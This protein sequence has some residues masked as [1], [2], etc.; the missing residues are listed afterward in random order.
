MKY[1]LN[2]RGNPTSAGAYAG[3]ITY[4]AHGAITNLT[5]G[6]GVVEATTWDAGLRWASITAS[7]GA[8]N[9]TITNT[10]SPNGN[11]KTQQVVFP[12]AN[13]TQTYE[14]ANIQNRLTG[15]SETG[16]GDAT[17]SQTYA[18]DLFG[19]RALTA[20]S[21]PEDLAMPT[22]L[23]Q[24]SQSAPYK[25]QIVAMSDGT[26][27]PAQ[28]YDGAGNLVNHPKMGQFAYDAEGRMTTATVGGVTTSFTYDGEGRRVT[29]TSAGATKI[30]VY[31]A[32]G[33]LMAEY[34]AA[35]VPYTRYL[36][37]DGLGST[38]LE[39]DAAGAVTSRHDYA[40]FGAELTS[41]SNPVRN[42]A[43]GFI[44]PEPGVRQE[45]TGKE[46][47]AETGLDY[48]GARYFNSAQ[49]RFTSPDRPLIDQFLDH[50]QSWNLYAYGRNNPL[51]YV[52]RTGEA[53]E[54]AGDEDER[55]KQLE[56]LQ[57]AV[58]SKAGAYLYQ[59]AEKDHNGNLT[60]RYS[61]VY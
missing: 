21:F 22:N 12:G 54:L 9:E 31:D 16:G 29:L 57:K 45:Y 36:T 55:K 23:T 34:G 20:T 17:W 28:A 38:R 56:G 51:R 6:N 33:A 27:M 47:D 46:R 41:V 24:Y 1:P 40:P 37:A 35:G 44:G 18:Y 4:S 61:S 42:L 43:N 60:G 7:K 30:F 50:P 39:T 49:G 25:N 5:M 10:F 11:V 53:I 8:L 59:N 26:A 13:Y 2:G 14:Y 32:A 19:N 48:F 58:G 15:V 52:D 3:A